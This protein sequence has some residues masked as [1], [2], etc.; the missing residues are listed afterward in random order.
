[1]STMKTKIIR[2][3]KHA[4]F[5]LLEILVS[6]IILAVGLLGLASLQATS[7][8]FNQSAYLRSQA[9]VLAYDMIDRMRANIVAAHNGNYDIAVTDTAPTGTSQLTDIDRRQWRIALSHLPSGT[10]GITHSGD[11]FTVIVQWD[12]SRGQ[13]AA[14]QFVVMTKL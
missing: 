4:G 5:T 14:Q 2:I 13:S 6:I 1:M 3:P 8:R 12:D 10:G 9:T 11:Q 7:I